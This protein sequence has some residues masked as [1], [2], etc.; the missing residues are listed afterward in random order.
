MNV[1]VTPDRK[2]WF[3]FDMFCNGVYGKLKLS[4]GADFE[5]KIHARF[6]VN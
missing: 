3:Y 6:M 2:R 1:E 4:Q 5:Y